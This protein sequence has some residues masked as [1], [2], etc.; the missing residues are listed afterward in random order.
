MKI[1]GM[2]WG[3]D[4]GGFGC[5]PISGSSIVEVAFISGNETIYVIDCMY[6]CYE[7]L[8]ITKKSYF[9]DLLET[10]ISPD[11]IEAIEDFEFVSEDKES[12]KESL[13]CMK[14]SDY[15]NAMR[16]VRFA[17]F[18]GEIENDE[19]SA[20]NFIKSY[21]GKDVNEIDIIDPSYLQKM[22]KYL[23]DHNV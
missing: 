12:E 22:E 3:Y 10:E 6:E 4:D 15:G 21:I 13:D 14:Q 7:H 23:S 18:S 11:E 17:M 19:E 1:V 16:F 9:T 5:G 8:W 20:Q 2:R